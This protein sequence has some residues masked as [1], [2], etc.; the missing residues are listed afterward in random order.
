MILT[1]WGVVGQS[2]PLHIMEKIGPL[3]PSPSKSWTAHSSSTSSGDDTIR[4]R[5]KDWANHAG[6]PSSEGRHELPR[7]RLDAK[8]CQC[9][10][11]AGD[12][13]LGQESHDSKHR[14]ATVVELR[15]EF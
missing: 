3:L 14:E 8:A 4:R 1:D 10:D 9:W 13:G 6:L 5:R 11:S 7:V 15:E 2:S 12:L